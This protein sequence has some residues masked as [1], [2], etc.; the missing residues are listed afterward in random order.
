MSAPITK[1]WRWDDADGGL[2][3]DSRYEVAPEHG[4]L[5]VSRKQ[6]SASA[7]SEGRL[8]SAADCRCWLQEGYVDETLHDL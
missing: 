5:S 1:A 4:W 8:Q 6:S 2:S 3:E 7:V